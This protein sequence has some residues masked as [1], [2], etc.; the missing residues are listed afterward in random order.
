MADIDFDELDRA[1]SSIMTE[2]DSKTT[3]DQ[4]DADTQI[5][6]VKKLEGMTQHTAPLLASPDAE[7]SVEGSKNLTGDE[8]KEATPDTPKV[9]SRPRG[10]FMDFKP[11]KGGSDNTPS[12]PQVAE[13]SKGDDQKSVE[14]APQAN[15]IDDNT[16]PTP[17]LSTTQNFSGGSSPTGESE[18]T[19][20]PTPITQSPFL[21]DA[22]VEKRPLGGGTQPASSMDQNQP[23]SDTQQPL[24]VTVPEEL[25]ADLMALESDTTPIEQNTTTSDSGT[26]EVSADNQLRDEISESDTISTSSSPEA[27]SEITGPVSIPP[28][29]KVSA[30]T[31]TNEHVAVYAPETTPTGL[32]Q[33]PKKRS[34]WLIIIAILLLLVLGAAGG[35]YAYTTNLF[36]SL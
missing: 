11:A 25:G 5:P 34:G 18:P 20:S 35:Y 16:P 17:P 31:E 1:V 27:A 23:A 10:R 36:G 3:T 22:K 7:S 21:P 13:T 33:P 14:E 4:S 12:T 30:P 15:Q 2:N 24:D 28:Q 9:V 8:T 6:E 29:Y 19:E 32:V 26:V